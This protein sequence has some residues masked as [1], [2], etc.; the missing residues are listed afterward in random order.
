MYSGRSSLRKNRLLFGCRI[1]FASAISFHSI[2]HNIYLHP[3]N[4]VILS[5][6]FNF[7]NTGSL[8]AHC[9]FAQKSTLFYISTAGFKQFWYT[10][11]ASRRICHIV[12]SLFLNTNPAQL[13]HAA[14]RTNDRR[15]ARLYSFYACFSSGMS[16]ERIFTSPLTN[17][18]KLSSSTMLPRIRTSALRTSPQRT[19]S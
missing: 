15:R 6:H 4:R 8:H 12:A 19:T 11:P 16:E 18:R 2:S 1:L 10:F 7:V 17:P 9:I 13:T 14:G 3:G 5:H